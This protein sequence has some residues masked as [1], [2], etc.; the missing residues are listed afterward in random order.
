MTNAWSTLRFA[1]GMTILS[2]VV[3]VAQSLVLVH[4][5]THDAAT[6]LASS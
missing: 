6:R 4:E 3:V 5:M 2:A 1:F